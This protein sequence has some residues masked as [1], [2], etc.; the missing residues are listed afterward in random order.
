MKKMVL[1]VMLI[2][3]LIVMTACT[4]QLENP[5]IVGGETGNIMVYITPYHIHEHLGAGLGVWERDAYIKQALAK[6][7][8]VRFIESPASATVIIETKDFDMSMWSYNATAVTRINNLTVETAAHEAKV[9]GYRGEKMYTRWA[10]GDA[11][12]VAIAV[13]KILSGQTVSKVS[14]TTIS[15]GGAYAGL[16]DIEVR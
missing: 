2:T 15:D 8:S 4:H 3:M 13:E 14:G 10:K 11:E 6:K 1:A 5:V 7:L 12:L 16:E 9:I